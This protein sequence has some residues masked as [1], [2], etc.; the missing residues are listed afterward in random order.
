[1]RIDTLRGKGAFVCGCGARI[2][3]TLPS[4]TPPTH[5]VWRNCRLIPVRDYEVPLCADHA[6]RLREQLAVGPE[7]EY[8]ADLM[9]RAHWGDELNEQE[10]ADLDAAELEWQSRARFSRDR[11]R[12]ERESASRV[13]FM[14]HDRII[15]IG[16]SVDPEKRAQA[17]ASA[18][19]LATEPGGRVLEEAMHAKFSHLRIRGEWFSPGPDLLAYINKLRGAA[20]LGAITADGEYPRLVA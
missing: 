9:R 8:K 7:A 5:C 15:K 20:G 16:F 11:E 19:I 14:R 18:V 2:A 13:Y 10:R 6:K 17:L 12:A 4:E 1:M 3:I